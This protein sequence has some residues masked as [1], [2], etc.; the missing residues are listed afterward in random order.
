[1]S[2]SLILHGTT[3]GVAVDRVSPELE[4]FCR[5]AVETQRERNT[6]GRCCTRC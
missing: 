5:E 6:E 3:R 4:N 1:M 2:T